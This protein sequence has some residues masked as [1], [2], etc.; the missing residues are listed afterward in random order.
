MHCPLE[1]KLDSILSTKLSYDEV[2]TE[3]PV[4]GEGSYGT[5]WLSSL[6]P[7]SFLLVTHWLL[8]I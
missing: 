4:I 6:S 5:V 2:T 7:I 8:G 3:G 1:I